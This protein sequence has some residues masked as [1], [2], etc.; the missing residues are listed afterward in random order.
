MNSNSFQF[1]RL[2][3]DGV[4]KIHDASL[5]IL[6]VRLQSIWDKTEPKLLEYFSDRIERPRP[7]SVN[8]QGPPSPVS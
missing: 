6:E 7:F 2:S 4:E 8:F 3:P 1:Q 5:E